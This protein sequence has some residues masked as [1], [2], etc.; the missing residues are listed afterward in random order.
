ML[1]ALGA[2]VIILSMI[3]LAALKIRRSIINLNKEGGTK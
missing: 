3:V 1:V 2:A